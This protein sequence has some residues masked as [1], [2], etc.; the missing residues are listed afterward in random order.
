MAL[1][2]HMEDLCSTTVSVNRIVCPVS[3]PY[4][5]GADIDIAQLQMMFVLLFP[6]G[7]VLPCLSYI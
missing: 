1:S 7:H 4:W 6:N 2:L 5:A 3:H